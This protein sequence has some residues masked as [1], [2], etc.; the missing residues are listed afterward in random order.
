[1]KKS[2]IALLLVLAVVS[3]GVFADSTPKSFEVKT[4]IDAVNDMK[5]VTASVSTPAGYGEA[6]GFTGQVT[7][8]GTDYTD[9]PYIAAMSNNRAGFTVALTAKA[10]ES[11]NATG[12]K[13]YIGYTVTAGESSV[14]VAAAD[15]TTVKADANE[16]FVIS[17]GTLNVLTAKSEQVSIAVNATEYAAA[18]DGTYTGTIYLTFAAL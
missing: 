15:T 8:D 6:A 14:V 13:T 1:M 5:L 17:S 11:G 7:Y 3:F 12:T 4:T 2:I 9:F 10:M 16:K 18:V